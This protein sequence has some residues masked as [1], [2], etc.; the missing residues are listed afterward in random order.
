MVRDAQRRG[1]PWTL[2]YTGRS[3]PSMPFVAELLEIAGDDP[4]RVSVRPDPEYGPDALP[5]VF[6]DALIGARAYACGPPGMIERL[7]R[8]LPRR[9][10]ETLHY[11]RFSAP[12][13]LGGEPF[14]IVLS[15]SR[16]T[17]PVGS[18]ESALTAVRRVL[19]DVAYSCQQGFCGTCRVRVLAG[20]VEHRDRALSATERRHEL[21]L[22]VSRGRGTLTLDL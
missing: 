6:D 3:R 1:V 4:G 5:S 2:V 7:R 12:A 13:V 11:E 15:R 9:G 14:E 20:S 16:R 19:P 8:E 22:C 21:A 10:I 18:Q 17:V